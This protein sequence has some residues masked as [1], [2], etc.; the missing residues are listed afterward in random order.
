M[1]LKQNREE[2]QSIQ[3]YAREHLSELSIELMGEYILDKLI[4]AILETRCDVVSADENYEEAV[5]KPPL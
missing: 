4:P 1:F 3:Q 2:M 5:Q